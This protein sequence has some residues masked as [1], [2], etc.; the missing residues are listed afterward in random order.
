M[1]TWRPWLKSTGPRTDA[2]KAIVSQ[3]SYRGAARHE[4]RAVARALRV[5]ASSLAELRGDNQAGP[6]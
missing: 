5:Q 6:R 1:R 3:N 2:G 4:L